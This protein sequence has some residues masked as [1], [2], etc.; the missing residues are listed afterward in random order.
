MIDA[1][2]GAGHR[3][4]PG[5]PTRI[6]RPIGSSSRKVA[7]RHTVVDDDVLGRAL[8]VSDREI[9]PGQ[10]RYPHRLEEARA[11]KVVVDLRR[12]RA[13]RRAAGYRHPGGH[14]E[15]TARRVH[16]DTDR[17]HGGQSA[18][19]RIEFLVERTRALAAIR[20]AGRHIHDEHLVLTEADVDGAQLLQAARRRDRQTSAEGRAA[21]PARPPSFG[22]RHV[23]VRSAPEALRFSL[24]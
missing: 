15:I 16:R 22:P 3:W 24:G 9:A 11:H 23:R 10:N 19:P 18:N 21:R 5:S 20:G 7:S 2:A 12:V 17:L 4:H 14:R 13:V 8:V 6:C 1:S